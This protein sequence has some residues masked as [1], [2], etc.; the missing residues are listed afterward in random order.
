MNV[1]GLGIVTKDDRFG[2]YRSEPVSVPMFGGKECRFILKGYAE[3]PK[4]EEFHAAIAN[5][6]S[7]SPIVLRDAQND[8]F[9]YYEDC[10]EFWE[11]D[12]NAPIAS[13][14]DVWQHV[15]LGGEPMVQRRAYGD[16][17]VYISIEC[18][19]DWEDEHGLQIVLKNGLKVNKLGPYNGHLTNSDAYARANLENVVYRARPAPPR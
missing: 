16:K 2:W 8:L 7:G 15:R 18:G 12:G 5:F 10:K 13:A 9:R 6:L 14:S 1:P 3:D 4:K 11:E 19:C 17:G